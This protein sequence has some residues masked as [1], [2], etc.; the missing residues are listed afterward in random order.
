MLLVLKLVSIASATGNAAISRCC[1]IHQ[2]NRSCNAVVAWFAVKLSLANSVMVAV[3][4]AVTRDMMQGMPLHDRH[5]AAA[6]A[7]M[8]LAA[9]LGLDDE[10]SSSEDD[11]P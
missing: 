6:S 8:R 1:C 4:P 5:D 3:C 11:G 2:C 10:S 7:A 9:A